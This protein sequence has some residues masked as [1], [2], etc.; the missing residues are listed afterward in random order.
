MRLPFLQVDFPTV[1]S[2]KAAMEK[3]VA[4]L[5]GNLETHDVEACARI[6]GLLAFAA[7]DDSV[8]F[9]ASPSG[10]CWLSPG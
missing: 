1:P 7:M 5:A 3:L 10:F 6:N 2:A 8:E 4:F 9:H